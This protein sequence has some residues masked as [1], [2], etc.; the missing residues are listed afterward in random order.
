MLDSPDDRCQGQAADALQG[1]MPGDESSQRGTAAVIQRHQRPPRQVGQQVPVP[2]LAQNLYFWMQ[3]TAV[4]G[5]G[6]EAVA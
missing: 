5:S 2:E 3:G 4:G 6:D 1:R